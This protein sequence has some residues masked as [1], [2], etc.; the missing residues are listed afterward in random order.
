MSKEIKRLS[1]TLG[2]DGRIRL[3]LPDGSKI[4]IKATRMNGVKETRLVFEMAQSI[5][6]TRLPANTHGK[7]T[8]ED[9]NDND[10]IENRYDESVQFDDNGKPV[11]S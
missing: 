9:T 3:D 11:V 7:D 4:N 6:A 10:N 2:M 8:M 1:L 5:R